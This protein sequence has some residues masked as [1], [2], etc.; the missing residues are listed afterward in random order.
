MPSRF[1]SFGNRYT[2]F[3]DRYKQSDDITWDRYARLF[4]N[5]QRR[6]LQLFEGQTR[7]KTQM[8]WRKKGYRVKELNI[9]RETTSPH[10]SPWTRLNQL[11]LNKVLLDQTKSAYTSD[12][13]RELSIATI[14]S[15]ATEVV[16]YTDGS[17]VDL[18]E[19]G[20]AGVFIEDVSGLPM[21]EASFPET[22]FV[23]CRRVCSSASCSRVAS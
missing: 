2:S 14:S 16:I 3:E 15:F 8:G 20:R 11:R 21:L 6:Q 4:E 17:T 5:D 19:N 12:E 9:V 1:P 23:V 22:L 18:Q 13:L 7:L 10:L